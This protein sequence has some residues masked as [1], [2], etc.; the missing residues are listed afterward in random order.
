MGAL[1]KLEKFFLANNLLTG[2][3]PF[4]LGALTEL[5]QLF[6]TNN[7]LIGPPPSSL[8]TECWPISRI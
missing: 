7:L 5:E 2:T 8:G 6:L 1:T 4:S 3:I